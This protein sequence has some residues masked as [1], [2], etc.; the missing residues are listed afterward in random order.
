MA[1]L[2]RPLAKL[3]G[4][5]FF[6]GVAL[7]AL[8]LEIGAW[9]PPLPQLSYTFPNESGYGTDI[10]LIDIQHRLSVRLTGHAASI[11]N[12]VWSPDGEHLAYHVLNPG[13][14]QLH[15]YTPR[16]GERAIFRSRPVF[17]SAPAWS[18]DSSRLALISDQ[19][20]GLF[21]LYIM[22]ARTAQ[23]TLLPTTGAPFDRTPV[24]SEAGDSVYFFSADE[25]MERGISRYDLRLGRA[26]VVRSYDERIGLLSPDLRRLMVIGDQSTFVIDDLSQA[27]TSRETYSLIPHVFDTPVGWSPDGNSL[28]FN[29]SYT[30]TSQ[31]YQLTLADGTIEP[32][33]EAFTVA[34]F[35]WSPDETFIALISIDTGQQ[36]IYVIN[37][38]GNNL[39]QIVRS[40]RDLQV[41]AWRGGEK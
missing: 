10:W 34:N 6:V 18:P 2:T 35:A 38:D 22:D 13:E 27:E 15:I 14:H 20:R 39:Q 25:H 37:S 17:P 36:T 16:T 7:C 30:G 11:N 28:M 26:E 29:S 19:D 33:A 21:K 5:L 24:W 3:T 1:T 9:L 40:F 32:L 31:L 41:I 23:L 4:V 12:L 8:M